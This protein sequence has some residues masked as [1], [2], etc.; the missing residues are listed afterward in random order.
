M[1]A[2]PPRCGDCPQVTDVGMEGASL[3][4]PVEGYA[5]SG[6]EPRADFQYLAC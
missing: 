5:V 6:L 1:T 3:K 4:S 2:D